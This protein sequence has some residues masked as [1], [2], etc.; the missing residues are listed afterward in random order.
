MKLDVVELFAGV[1]GFRVGFNN[2]VSFD[3]KTELANEV[4][5]WNF[6][7]SNQWEPSTKIQPAYEC[8]IKRF[9]IKNTSNEDINKVNKDNIPEHTVL[10]GGFPCQDYSVARSKAN[11]M[12]IKGKKGVLWWDIAE[13]IFK[14]RPPFILLEN[15]DRLL[16]SPANQRGRDFSVMLKTF[17]EYGYV[18]EWRMINPAEYGMPQKRKR[19]FIFAS[20]KNTKYAKNILKIKNK[21][22]YL[23][24]KSFYSDIFPI[25][26]DTTNVFKKTLKKYKDNVNA[27]LNYNQ[28]K[29]LNLGLFVEGTIYNT[30]F[31]EKSASKYYTLEEIIN[32]STKYNNIIEN[33]VLKKYELT[34]W[35]ELKNKKKIPRIKP[36][37]EKYF[38]SE[39]TMSFPD[40]LHMPGRTILTSEGSANRSSHV[41]FDNKIN[42]YRKITEVEAELLQMFPPNWTKTGMTS[43]QRYFMMGNALVTGVVNIISDKLKEIVTNE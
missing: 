30:D 6:V 13:I 17:E 7:W 12:G 8:Y 1:G 26:K 41:I 37:G 27:S 9:G 43:R 38:Y 31:R 16:K 22:E 32:K 25:L 18:V 28:D 42:K 15:V 23:I 14:K 11:E 24:S 20:N 29:F 21:K 34:K 39:G 4:K 19:I 3:V 2:I 5:T 35:E 10:V 36:N 33:Y 40:K